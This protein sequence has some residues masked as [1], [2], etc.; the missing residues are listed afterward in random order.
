MSPL[1]TSNVSKIPHELLAKIFKFS[2]MSPIIISSTVKNKNM[3]LPLLLVCKQWSHVVTA[4][5]ESWTNISVDYEDQP[6]VSTSRIGDPQRTTKNACKALLRSGSTPL[7]LAIHSHRFNAEAQT[8]LV[9]L[10]ILHSH[11][12]KYLKLVLCEQTLCNQAP[13]DF[14]RLAFLSISCWLWNLVT[15][16]GCQSHSNSLES[17]KA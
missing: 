16:I 2:V 8:S 12:L 15:M 11:R 10:I 7:A 6:W 1:F 14:N 4:S 13:L 9:N 5:P 17:L 3:P